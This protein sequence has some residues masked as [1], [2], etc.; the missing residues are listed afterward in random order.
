VL[1]D[2]KLYQYETKEWNEQQPNSVVQINPSTIIK[3]QLH[4]L[5]QI[6]IDNT[7]Q[8]SSKNDIYEWLAALFAAQHGIDEFNIIPYAQTQQ[9]TADEFTSDY[10]FFEKWIAC[11]NRYT[12]SQ[13]CED[14]VEV[15]KA[16][17]FMSYCVQENIEKLL[18]KA[19]GLGQ[20]WNSKLRDLIRQRNSQLK[21]DEHVN[22]LIN[23]HLTIKV[24]Q[25]QRLDAL[26]IKSRCIKAELETNQVHEEDFSDVNLD[27]RYVRFDKLLHHFRTLLK[28]EDSNIVGLLNRAA[29][30]QSPNSPFSVSVVTPGA[31]SATPTLT[32]LAASPGT[33]LVL[34][35]RSRRSLNETQLLDHS[36]IASTKN[37]I[38][39]KLRSKLYEYIMSQPELNDEEHIDL[40]L[41]RQQ[42]STFTR[43]MIEMEKHN[44]I[45]APITTIQSFIKH[46]ADH[47]L[48]KHPIKSSRYQLEALDAYEVIEKIMFHQDQF[49]NVCHNNV[50]DPLNDEKFLRK[51]GSEYVLK[52]LE[53]HE[54]F[55][56]RHEESIQLLRAVD[57]C[58]SPTK[59]LYCITR[60]AKRVM[61][62]MTHLRK[63]SVISTDH[64]LPVFIGVVCC[65]K[66]P[67]MFTQLQFVK[68]Y[69]HEE[70]LIGE[71]GF[72]F[73]SLESAAT[74][75]LE[76]EEVSSGV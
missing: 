75:I 38:R 29:R 70:M 40:S 32:P 44:E 62:V 59:K 17:T 61:A 11:R 9:E 54:A 56:K 64:F 53:L 39:R 66:L 49:Y 51:C 18:T 46:T 20:K 7:L 23:I 52:N 55:E 42:I 6:T 72:Y 73:S 5:P 63:E 43:S 15:F 48:R 1:K 58:S 24:Y 3:T 19:Q 35:P 12:D 30:L 37:V 4:K 57:E 41:Y 28:R 76:Q 14:A 74:F 21:D 25:L 65:T 60:A 67:C 34:T 68:R 2:S 16:N 31:N 26:M 47:L 10:E 33:L 27:P 50:E 8:L 36:A 71:H 22:E 13:N 69:A 45:R